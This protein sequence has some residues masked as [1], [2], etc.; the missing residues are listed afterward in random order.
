MTQRQRQTQAAPSTTRDGCPDAGELRT[1]SDVRV[2]V[3]WGPETSVDA[4]GTLTGAM[5]PV[6]LIVSCTH[7]KKAVVPAPLCARTLRS[8]SL[9]D[10]LDE[11]IERRETHVAEERRASDLYAGD[12][13]QVAQSVARVAGDVGLD[14]RLWVCSAG[15][16]LIRA[17]TPVKPYSYTFAARHADSVAPLVTRDANGSSPSMWWSGLCARPASKAPARGIAGL[18]ADEPGVPVVVVASEPYVTAMAEDLVE[19]LAAL[20]SQDLLS[21]VSS[22]TDAKR[23]PE[24]ASCLLPADARFEAIV[25]GTRAA[26]NVR[27]ARLMFQHAD[28]QV[29]S[30]THLGATLER[31]SSTLPPLRRFTRRR[32]SDDDVRAFI[33][34]ARQSDPSVSKTHLLRKLRAGDAACEQA[35]FSDIFNQEPGRDGDGYVQQRGGAS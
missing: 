13:W 34:E 1:R 4:L 29:L 18:A 21:I 16:G 30:R 15:Y 14:V 8:T 17:S 31:L 19:A 26:L 7:R 28:G 24:L 25:G 35:R 23:V 33:E 10:R 3:A 2:G 11:W 22:G 6:N 9:L 20:R 27:I 12:H 5:Q 32:L